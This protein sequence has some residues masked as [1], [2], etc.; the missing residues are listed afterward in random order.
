MLRKQSPKFGFGSDIRKFNDKSIA[1]GP[2]NYEIG[3]IVGKDGPSKTMHSTIQ[4]SPERK[5]GSFKP[6]PG[7]YNPD[8]LKTRKKDPAFRVG[9]G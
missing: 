1:P 5:E 8:L 3:D 9:S 4:Y 6:G 2:G 7:Q